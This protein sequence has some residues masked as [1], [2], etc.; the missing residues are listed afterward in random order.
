MIFCRYLTLTAKVSESSFITV[1][2]A[3]GR[4][5]RQTDTNPSLS[6]GLSIALKYS[7][8]PPIM[9]VVYWKDENGDDKSFCATEM[10]GFDTGGFVRENYGH[11]DNVIIKR[12]LMTPS[13]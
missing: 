9:W 7:P 8:P 12:I 6:A 2:P 3:H 10:P 4:I 5:A 1:K 13:D 11:K